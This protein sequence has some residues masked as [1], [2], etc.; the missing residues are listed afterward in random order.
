ME[1]P[2]TSVNSVALIALK[3]KSEKQN[4]IHM[5]TRVLIILVAA[6]ALVSF[7]VASTTKRAADNS[8]AAETYHASSGQVMH[9][10]DQFN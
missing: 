3:V 2:A 7:T 4:N 10:K 9:D 8:T 5:K 1:V 6:V